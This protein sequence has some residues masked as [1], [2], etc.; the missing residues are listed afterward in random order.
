MSL[1]LH[2]IL[3]VGFWLV[4]SSLAII[5]VSCQLGVHLPGS[6]IIISVMMDRICDAAATTSADSLCLPSLTTVLQVLRRLLVVVEIV[7]SVR[8]TNLS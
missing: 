5:S 7:D 8:A 2:P 3:I 1:W 4:V 6:D